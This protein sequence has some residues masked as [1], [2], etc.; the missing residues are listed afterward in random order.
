MS[1][2]STPDAPSFGRR[3]LKV[4]VGVFV[5]FF[6]VFAYMWVSQI[7]QVISTGDLAGNAYTSAPVVFWT[8]RYLD[9]GFSIPF[10]LLALF[11]LLSNPRKAYSL[12]L[13]FFGFGLTTGTAVNAVAIV[14]VF[15][16]DPSVTGAA[17]QGLVVFPILGILVYAGFFYLI[18][19]K[20]RRH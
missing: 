16:H 4:Y 20:L 18:R 6:L 12:V 13:L 15:N 1:D 19:D 7:A 9:L 17:A 5:L 14:E 2:G 10:G 11:L 3:G 8:I